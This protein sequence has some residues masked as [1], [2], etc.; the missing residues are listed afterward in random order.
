MSV[1][2]IVVGIPWLEMTRE[3]ERKLFE[4]IK[5]KLHPSQSF[6]KFGHQ[7][8]FAI[9]ANCRETLLWEIFLYAEMKMKKDQQFR[10]VSQVIVIQ[11][12]TC[13]VT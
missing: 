1:K 10:P 6:L 3:K 4:K 2:F 8:L 7:D 11:N 13:E 5:L 12:I 9:N